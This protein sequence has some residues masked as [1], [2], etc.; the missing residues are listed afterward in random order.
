MGKEKLNVVNLPA[1]RFPTALAVPV[2][3]RA[4]R[5]TLY[6]RSSEGHQIFQETHENKKWFPG[7][8][9]PD[10]VYSTDSLP[11]VVPDADVLNII[12]PAR[13]FRELYRSIYPYID[14]SRFAKEGFIVVGSKGFEEETA[15]RISEIVRQETPDLAKRTVVISG[16]NY[17][18]EIV[19][20]LPFGIVLASEDDV[21]AEELW[22]KLFKVSGTTKA[23]ITDDVIGVEL[24]GILGKP[25]AMAVGI[26]DG[27]GMGRNAAHLLRSRGLKEIT[28]LAVVLGA[29]RNTLSGLSGD[30]DLALSSEDPGRNYKAGFEIGEQRYPED[31]QLVIQKL[32]QSR[33][34]IEGI[35]SVKSII[36]L[37][38]RGREPVIMPIIENLYKIFYEG[39]TPQEAQ[40]I[41]MSTDGK[42]ED[43]QPVIDRRLRFPMRAIDRIMHP[44]HRGR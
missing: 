16:P 12:P 1:G 5:V 32:L 36:A 41:L 39:L 8:K 31:L 9:L 3:L 44:W 33:D 15:L 38:N 11:E 17:A 21:V 2:A 24:G 18:H 28:R 6:F 27:M 42:Y 10:N 35:Q 30:E 43:P 22:K 4:K 26:S 7:I 25:I 19:Q 14:R 40:E 23:Y 37:A 29:D 34:T 20:G 13:Y